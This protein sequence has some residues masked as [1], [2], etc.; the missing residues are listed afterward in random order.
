MSL[1]ARHGSPGGVDREAW[2]GVIPPGNSKENALRAPALIVQ[3]AF[4]PAAMGK[5][6]AVR[7]VVVRCPP[8]AGDSTEGWDHIARG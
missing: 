5:G 4:D 3:L 8:W 7:P 2:G 1:D 6:S